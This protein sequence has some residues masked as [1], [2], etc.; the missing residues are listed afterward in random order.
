MVT[1]Q[2]FEKIQNDLDQMDFSQT[3]QIVEIEISTGGLTKRDYFAAHAL[4]GLFSRGGATSFST[5]FC[6][7]EAIKAA[8]LMLEEMKNPPN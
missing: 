2:T 4:V 1:V 6:V 5:T 8:N 3:K 7:S